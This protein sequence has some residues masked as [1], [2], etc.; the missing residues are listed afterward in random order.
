MCQSEPTTLII[1]FIELFPTA[2]RFPIGEEEE[3]VIRC[4]NSG[5][6]HIRD[7]V[8]G[9]YSVIIPVHIVPVKSELRNL[10]VNES[11]PASSIEIDVSF[12][13][14]NTCLGAEYSLR[15]WNVLVTL[16]KR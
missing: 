2:S 15:S 4:H 16:E 14:L 3:H 9:R 8:S 10:E 13:C 1:K 6:R 12:G 11:E 5:T 7:Q